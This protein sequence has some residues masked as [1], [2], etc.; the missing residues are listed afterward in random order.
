MLTKTEVHN[1]PT[2]AGTLNRVIKIKLDASLLAGL[3]VYQF[4]NFNLGRR[5]K[6]SAFLVAGGLE[7]A[8]LNLTRK[9][10]K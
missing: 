5:F 6:S 10:G 7:N 1:I 2:R 4:Y 3:C 8:K 9:K